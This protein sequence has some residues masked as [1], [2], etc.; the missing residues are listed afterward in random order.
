MNITPWPGGEQEKHSFVGDELSFLKLG[1]VLVGFH[2]GGGGCIQGCPTLGLLV[3]V[4]LIH[5]GDIT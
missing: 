3:D 5:M 1:S 4:I 2:L